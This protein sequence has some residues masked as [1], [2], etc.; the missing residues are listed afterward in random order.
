MLFA[1]S[2]ATKL[3]GRGLLAFSVHPGAIFTNLG[4]HLLTGDT[5]EEQM[6][7]VEGYRE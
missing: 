3:G 6:K 2:L 4:N 7:W 5:Q 1:R